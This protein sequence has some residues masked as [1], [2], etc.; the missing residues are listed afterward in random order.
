MI[1]IAMHGDRGGILQKEIS[2]KQEISFKYLD[3]IIASLKAS[4]L[5]VNASGRMSGYILSRAPE[6]IS[7]YDVYKA[8]EKE[9]FIA[10]C[11]TEEGAGE[12]DYLY[13]VREF[14]DG[15]NEAIKRH[16]ESVNLKELAE[17]QLEF[18]ERK[19]DNMFYI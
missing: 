9:L 2:E 16:L 5:I 1:E 6:E 11:L 4:D 10:D 18:Q 12:R 8:F 14:W 19:A 3:P 7:V 15:L 17:K 13:A